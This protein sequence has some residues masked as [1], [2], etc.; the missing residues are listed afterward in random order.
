MK[1]KYQQRKAIITSATIITEIRPST[2]NLTQA[3]RASQSSHQNPAPESFREMKR[4]K[5]ANDAKATRKESI[6]TGTG[7]PLFGII[8]KTLVVLVAIPVIV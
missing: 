5:M 8:N 3:A 6:P 2:S 1:L 7:A 4:T